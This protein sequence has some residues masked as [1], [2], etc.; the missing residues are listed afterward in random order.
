M[1]DFILT[2]LTLGKRPKFEYLKDNPSIE[3]AQNKYGFECPEE[4]HPDFN[5]SIKKAV[6]KY[7]ERLGFETDA[8]KWA[9]FRAKKIHFDGI[10]V[11]MDLVILTSEAKEVSVK[12]PEFSF[13]EIVNDLTAESEAYINGTKRKQGELFAKD[14]LIYEIPII[15]N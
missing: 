10:V 8:D 3:G 14:E 9:T 2:K 15:D 12:G 1:S 6:K 4:V 7:C 11:K 13:A 5:K